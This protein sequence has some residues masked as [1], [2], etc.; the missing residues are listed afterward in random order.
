M[1][2]RLTKEEEARLIQL[3]EEN[4]M[5]KTDVLK[6]A[7]YRQKPVNAPLAYQY[8][9]KM[10]VAIERIE[11]LHGPTEYSNAIREGLMELCHI[12]NS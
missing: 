12:L 1:N 4:N 2:L 5:T 7:L 9:I 6:Q 3:A 8:I 11:T 10:S